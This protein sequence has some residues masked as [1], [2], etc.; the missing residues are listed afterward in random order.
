MIS[1]GTC[2]RRD[3]VVGTKTTLLEDRSGESLPVELHSET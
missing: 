2:D 3:E 1:E